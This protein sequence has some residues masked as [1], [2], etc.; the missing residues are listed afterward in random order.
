MGNVTRYP[1]GTF[2]WIDL[3]TPD[4]DGAKVFYRDLFGWDMDDRP[5][6]EGRT[7][8]VG[9]L[10][11]KDVAAIHEDGKGTAAW[12]SYISVDDVDATTSSAQEL[13]ARTLTEPFDVRDAGRMSSIEDP[14][15]AVVG[16]W[17]PRGHIGAGYVN[18]ANAWSWNELVTEAVDDAQEFYGDLFGWEAQEIPAPMRR[19]SFSL[20]DLLIGGIH[21]PTPPEGDTS[22][23]TVSFT[24]A[25][26]DVSAARVEGLG[27]RV[28][29]P[30]MDIPIG[31]FS[32]VSDP[33]G[34]TF[35]LAAVPGGALRGVDGS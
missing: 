6:G 19:A 14:A 28:L 21:A 4:V 33:T 9:R 7:Y 34:A 10:N 1:N 20:G 11:G 31:R 27:G 35:T 29:L 18:D 24:V 13:G 5:A 30:P 16:L 23:W 32:I 3:G 17:Q 22:R 26:A 12:G 8:T 15:G 25:D 2:C